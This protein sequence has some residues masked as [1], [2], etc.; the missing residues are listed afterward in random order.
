MAQHG[1]KKMPFVF[2]PEI[3]DGERGLYRFSCYPVARVE[4]WTFW[5]AES[6]LRCLG[7]DAPLEGESLFRC[8]K[9]VIHQA[10]LARMSCGEPD[11]EHVLSLQDFKGIVELAEASHPAE[12]MN[13][14]PLRMQVRARV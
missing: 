12:D 6:T 7:P 1:D 8:H 5:I 10:A 4:R 13:N 14:A 9:E 2:S 11:A 3:R